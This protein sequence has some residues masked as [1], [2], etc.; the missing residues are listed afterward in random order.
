MIWTPIHPINATP[1]FMLL[2]QRLLSN[3]LSGKIAPGQKLPA[4][5]Q[6]AEQNGLSAT[7]V[8]RALESLEKENIIITIRAR[9]KYITSDSEVI[10]FGKKKYIDLLVNTLTTELFELGL[11]ESQIKQELLMHL[12]SGSKE[13]M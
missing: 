5:K 3:I 7:T 11:S 12:P 2:A 10:K 6:I 8:Q 13:I 1:P 4:V 9:G